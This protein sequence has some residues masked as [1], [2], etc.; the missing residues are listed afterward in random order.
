MVRF[1]GLPATYEGTGCIREG[2]ILHAAGPAAFDDTL[3]EDPS[4]D[5]SPAP[6]ELHEREEEEW[7]SGD[8]AHILLIDTGLVHGTLPENRWLRPAEDYDCETLP[9][10]VVRQFRL[11]HS[12][13]FGGGRGWK[14][15]PTIPTLFDSLGLAWHDHPSKKRPVALRLRVIRTTRR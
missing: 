13:T 12:A 3:I 9:P 8:A 10:N 7:T 2:M 6:I 15:E 4:E 14:C 11:T 1:V 5:D